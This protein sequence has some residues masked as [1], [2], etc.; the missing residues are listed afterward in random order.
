[1]A[2]ACGGGR[3]GT[4]QKYNLIDRGTNKIL[5]TYS[6][7]SEARMASARTSNTTVRAA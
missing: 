2:C 6:S 5:K 3:I 1:M 7:E 4:A